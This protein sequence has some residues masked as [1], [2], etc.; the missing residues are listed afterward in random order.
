MA[1]SFDRIVSSEV[2]WPRQ[3]SCVFARDR[4]FGSISDAALRKPA[5][6]PS[7]RREGAP[8]TKDVTG[9]SSPHVRVAL[10]ALALLASAG[11]SD[12]LIAPTA[13]LRPAARTDAD[14][15][16]PS[17]L[18]ENSEKYADNGFSVLTPKTLK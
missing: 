2:L 6:P 3:S 15:P 1:C 17:F 12:Q 14:T 18:H 8:F 9:M 13:S 10:G 7:P 5:V 4:G 11:C 16:Q